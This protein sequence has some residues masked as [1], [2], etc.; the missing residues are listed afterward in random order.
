M[1]KWTWIFIWLLP[2][3]AQADDDNWTMY[4]VALETYST[5]LASCHAFYYEIQ[6][7]SDFSKIVFSHLEQYHGRDTAYEVVFAAR[8][9]TIDALRFATDDYMA[10]WTQSRS[11]SCAKM[12]VR[13]SEAK[14]TSDEKVGRK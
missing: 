14:Q 13:I 3:A 7:N 5:D 10:L 8:Q 4:T 2:L 12:L 11:Q 1:N 9:A 6:E